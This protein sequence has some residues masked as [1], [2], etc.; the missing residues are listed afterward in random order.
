MHDALQLTPTGLE[1]RSLVVFLGQIAA[2]QQRI[3]ALDCRDD[4]R[5]V[6]VEIGGPQPLDI[7]AG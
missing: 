4:D 3:D 6:L 1:T 2:G 5:N 7:V